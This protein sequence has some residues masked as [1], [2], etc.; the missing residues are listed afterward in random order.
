L[1]MDNYEQAGRRKAADPP[2]DAGV[3]FTAEW[4]V[5]LVVC[6]GTQV[7]FIKTTASRL[8]KGSSSRP[9]V[10]PHRGGFG[11]HLFCCCCSAT[12]HRMY[13]GR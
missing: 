8:S 3:M 2:L 5:P 4:W 9:T 1:S 7:R 10:F 6:Q 12:S 13:S 11:P